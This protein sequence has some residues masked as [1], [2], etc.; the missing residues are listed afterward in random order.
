LPGRVIGQEAHAREPAEADHIGS[1]I[2]GCVKRIGQGQ[3]PMLG[4]GG[5]TITQTNHIWMRPSMGPFQRS[6]PLP[7][8]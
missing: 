7:I 3:P 8:D 2:C 4:G 6:A 1:E 5:P